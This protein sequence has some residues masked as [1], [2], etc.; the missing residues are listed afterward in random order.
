MS[1]PITTEETSA[2]HPAIT[3]LVQQLVDA[4]EAPG[5]DDVLDCFAEHAVLMLQDQGQALEGRGAIRTHFR[6]RVPQLRLHDGME[7][8]IESL[9]VRDPDW[10]LAKVLLS[11][12]L[13]GAPVARLTLSVTRVETRWRITHALWEAAEQ[14]RAA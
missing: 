11:R 13:D 7:A 8:G 2:T 14:R 3:G 1:T 12:R 4:I 9:K 6:Y 5:I 10:G